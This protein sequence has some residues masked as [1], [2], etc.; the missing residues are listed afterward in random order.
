MTKTAYLFGE[1]HGSEAVCQ[2]EFEIWQDFYKRGL[3]HLF[4]ELPYFYA[5]FLNLWIKS[6]DDNI[7]CELWEN[8]KGTQGNSN[9]NREFFVEIKKLCPET[10]FHGTDIGHAFNT[11]GTRYLE[12]VSPD[13]AEYRIAAENIEQGK[14]YY[15]TWQENGNEDYIDANRE[16]S[17][18]ENFIREFDSLNCD[19]VGFYGEAH[20]FSEETGNFGIEKNM[21]SAIKNHYKDKINIKPELIKNL[22]NPLFHSKILINGKNYT[23]E[24]FGKVYTPF[25]ENCEYIEI[26]RIAEPEHDFEKYVRQDNFIPEALYPCN[27]ENGDIFVI[28]S[29][30]EN[31]AVLRQIFI[32]DGFS[33]EYGKITT[34][35]LS[36]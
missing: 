5:Q 7:L 16:K 20:V 17:M 25:D 36:E 19:I 15:K 14:I 11:I 18:T 28:D 4:M 10:V 12:T 35:I 21:C 2:K 1:I 23:A 34:E 6:G 33:E 24:N 22:I 30:N 9:F 8:G 29:I 13:S 32:C 26:F 27:M 31:K 3:R